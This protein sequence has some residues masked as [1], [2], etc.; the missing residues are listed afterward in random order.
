MVTLVL[1]LKLRMFFWYLLFC[2]RNSECFY[3]NS[4]SVT[5]TQNVSVVILVLLQKLKM[6]EMCSSFG[7][8]SDGRDGFT[9]Q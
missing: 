6:Y 4:C 5:E 8:K 2:Y 9:A 3:G 7:G 1:L